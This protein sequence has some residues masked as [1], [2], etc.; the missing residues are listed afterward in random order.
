MLY[1]LDT[2][3]TSESSE[4]SEERE[5][6]EY[7]E[8]QNPEVFTFTIEGP[9]QIYKIAMYLQSKYRTMFPLTNRRR[10]LK[11]HVFQTTI[12]QVRVMFWDHP[13]VEVRYNFAHFVTEQLPIGSTFNPDGGYWTPTSHFV[14]RD[15]RTQVFMLKGRY[16]QRQDQLKKLYKQIEERRNPSYGQD[17][18]NSGNDDVLIEEASAKNLTTY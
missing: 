2:L 12:E 7:D 9:I 1:Q 18:N 10:R 15:L 16:R 6:E 13:L 3:E 8:F 17:S 11:P 5:E 14:L 4:D